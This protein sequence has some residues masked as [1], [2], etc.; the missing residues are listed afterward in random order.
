MVRVASVALVF[1]LAGCSGGES[2][3]PVTPPEPVA[4][5]APVEPAP[6]APASAK[7]TFVSPADGAKVK[8]PVHVVMGVE[9][10]EVKPAGELVAGSGHHHLIING[11]PIESG[12]VVPKDETHIL[13]WSANTARLWYAATW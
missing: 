4:P 1:V 8:S 7:V 10:M 13:T 5:E 2:P 3:P 12:V 6:A 11:S 9:G